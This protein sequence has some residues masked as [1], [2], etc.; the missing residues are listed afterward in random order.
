MNKL[1][2]FMDGIVKEHEETFDENH[3][4]DFVDL[5]VQIKRTGKLDDNEVFTSK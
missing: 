3:I 2:E 1:A 4:R 5:Y